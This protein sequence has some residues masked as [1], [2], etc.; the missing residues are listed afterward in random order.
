[1]EIEGRDVAYPYPLQFCQYC[2]VNFDF[3]FPKPDAEMPIATDGVLGGFVQFAVRGH[4]Y[5]K[6][7]MLCTHCFHKCS[8]DKDAYKKAE[9]DARHEWICQVQRGFAAGTGRPVKRRGRKGP[10]KAAYNKGR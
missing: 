7:Y 10:K 8:D 1:M 9:F 6:M 2:K 5:R 4:A 3:K